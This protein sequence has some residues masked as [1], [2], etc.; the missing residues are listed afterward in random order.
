MYKISK[1]IEM[2]ANHLQFAL[3]KT[4]EQRNTNTTEETHSVTLLSEDSSSPLA[5]VINLLNSKNIFSTTKH[6]T[7][8][9]FSFFNLLTMSQVF[10]LLG[11]S[12]GVTGKER[13]VQSS[14]SPSAAAEVVEMHQIGNGPV[15]T[16]VS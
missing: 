1:Y 9:Y 3:D 8:K 11:A 15:L 16:M 5:F 13:R 12:C 7:P 4:A 6:Q 10:D 14:P 2:N